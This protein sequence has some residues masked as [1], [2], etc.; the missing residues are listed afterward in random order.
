MH[1]QLSIMNNKEYYEWINELSVK[2]QR[3]QIKASISVNSEMLRFYW[4]L[5]KEISELHTQS[6]WGKGFFD[7]LS[8]DLKNKIP[9]AKCFSSR[10]LRYMKRFYELFSHKDSPEIILPQLGAKLY[11]I[12]WGHIKLLI[13]KCNNDYKKACFFVNKT[14]E[15]NWSRAILL[16]FIDTDLYERQGKAIS[17]FEYRL[18]KPNSLLAQEI[19]KDPY[20]FDFLTIKENY[21]EKE[22]KEALL[23]N[24]Q[25]FLLE[26]G[27]GFAFVGKEYRLVV[28]NS[29]EFLDLLFYNIKLHC[30]VVVEVKIS[31]F[32]PQDIGQIGTY[33]TAV[34]HTLKGEKDETTIGLLICKTKDSVLAKYATES[35][36]QPIGISEYQLSNLIE[37]NY[38]DALPSIEQLE[39]ELENKQF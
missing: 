3:S 29:E 7:I 8:R 14:I 13:D 12:P 39:N 24:I 1:E 31:S 28:G 15:N 38:K 18:P 23:E 30:Y 26:L 25:K 9:N 2:Y 21:N 10:N 5:G 34:N 22:L 37:E 32:R 6:D 27:T 17:N 33:I 20:N 19:T 16:N 4:E 35:S 11:L 36:S